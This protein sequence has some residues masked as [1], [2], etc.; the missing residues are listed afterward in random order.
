MIGA[1][2]QS[3]QGPAFPPG[4]S[5]NSVAPVAG[6][7]AVWPLTVI[8]TCRYLLWYQSSGLVLGHWFL[9]IVAVLSFAPGRVFMLPLSPS[10][11]HGK[12]LT[13]LSVYSEAM[14]NQGMG[15]GRGYTGMYPIAV[16]ILGFLGKVSQKY[17]PSQLSSI[18]SDFFLSRYLQLESCKL[19]EAFC[20]IVPITGLVKTRSLVALIR[21]RGWVMR[22]ILDKN[23]D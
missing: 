7:S 2:S 12:Q 20:W 21:R 23:I 6:H 8:C 9:K 18:P 3:I 22:S 16:S 4:W 1:K 5:L 14:G 19:N 13:A 11:E 15:W 10:W 17:H